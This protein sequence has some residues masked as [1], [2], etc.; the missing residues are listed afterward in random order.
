[1]EKTTENIVRQLS[2]LLERDIPQQDDDM[3]ATYKMVRDT[4][5]AF[6][7][8]GSGELGFPEYVEAWQFMSRPGELSEIKETFDAVDIDGSGLID[9]N[10]FAFSLMGEAIVN[11][12]PLA[13]LETLTDLLTDTAGLLASLKG[14]LADSQAAMNARSERNGELRSRLEQMK[15]EM[16]GKMGAVMSKMMN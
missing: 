10:E 14:E 7:E 9:F 1:M 8:D 13:N 6:D 4:F 2:A 11:F 5:G 15:G 16:S 3:A 12:G